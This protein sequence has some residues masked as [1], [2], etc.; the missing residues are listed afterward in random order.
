MINLLSNATAEIP[1]MPITLHSVMPDTIIEDD[2]A[3][4]SVGCATNSDTR[5]I[6]VRF[7]QKTYISMREELLQDENER[8]CFAFGH[9]VESPQRL[10]MLVTDV[11]F[12]DNDTYKCMSPGSLV[13]NGK[14]KGT[15][16]DMYARSSFPLIINAHSH[17]F[18]REDV[19]FSAVD[20]ADDRREM[21]WIASELPKAKRHYGNPDRVIALSMVF[22]QTAIDAR[23]YTGNLQRPFRPVDLIEVVGEQ[24]T[25]VVPSSTKQ[26]AMTGVERE[27]LDRQLRAFTSGAQAVLSR[28][29]V[30]VV[31]VGGI[32]SLALQGLVHMGFRNIT[33]IDTDDIEWSNGNRLILWSQRNVGARKVEVPK[34]YYESHF[35]GVTIDAICAPLESMRAVSAMKDSDILIGG[36][37]NQGARVFLNDIAVQFL[38][39]YIDGA[40][41]IARKEGALSLAARSA[42]T[43]PGTTPCM[44][45]SERILYLDKK[46]LSMHFSDAETK[47][48]LRAQGY[49]KDA[50]EEKAPAVLP[51]NMLVASA[52]LFEVMNLVHGFQSG[53][54]CVHIDWMDNKG[55]VRRILN[56]EVGDGPSESCVVCSSY[57]G[58]GDSEP[59]LFPGA[60]TEL[61]PAPGM[62][63]I[64]TCESR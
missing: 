64:E 46:E 12:F 61:P 11:L 17:P 3:M 24:L 33:I 16:Y 36:L 38:I 15:A 57:L 20:D 50:P 45:C 25:L 59:I 8:I 48:H 63:E 60:Q 42:A 34:Q 21:G 13:L 52:I 44:Q 32:G 41:A 58:K 40:T 19:W 18:S 30:T 47:S 10:V 35:P 31:G 51:L 23:V 27:F 2:V 49:I 26:W 54:R 29:K 56:H 14:A 5:S 9:R 37:D 28:L 55:P 7:L 43:I 62:S 1:V 4:S 6:V 53:A 39:P 22:G